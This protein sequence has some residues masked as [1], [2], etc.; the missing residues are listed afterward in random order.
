MV[1]IT[2]SKYMMK[3]DIYSA[4]VVFDQFTNQAKRVWSYEK[5]VDCLVRGIVT[6]STGSNSAN[7]VT[8]KYIN[9]PENTLKMRTKEAIDVSRR[10][11]NIRNSDGVIIYKENQ[12]GE[13]SGGLGFQQSTIFEPRGSTPIV[14]HLGNIL[15]HEIMLERKEIQVLEIE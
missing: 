6:T 5:T 3:A 14:D 8:G 13:E 4:G 9:Y 11:V 2:S 1:C 7:Y 10:V 15:E 12:Y